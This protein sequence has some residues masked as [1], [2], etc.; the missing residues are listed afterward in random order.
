MPV[1]PPLYRLADHNLS[2]IYHIRGIARSAWYTSEEF[3]EQGVDLESNAQHLIPWGIPIHVSIRQPKLIVDVGTSIDAPVAF[4]SADDD[5]YYRIDSIA[6]EHQSELELF[7]L[8]R[9]LAYSIAM[10]AKTEVFARP[11]SITDSLSPQWKSGTL[12]DVWPDVVNI[13]PP[14]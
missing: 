5:V 3:E 13:F 12:R 7:R 9:P 1:V 10:S 11:L 14:R 6:P 2:T 8:L 4:G